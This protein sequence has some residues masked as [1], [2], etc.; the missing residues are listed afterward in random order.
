MTL[1]DM[2]KQKAENS[3]LLKIKQSKLVPIPI[4]ST[5]NVPQ[6]S[7]LATVPLNQFF[8]GI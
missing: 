2:L 7:S 5:F 4:S 1:E 8:R 6:P 3:N